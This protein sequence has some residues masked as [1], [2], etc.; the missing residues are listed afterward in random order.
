[1]VNQKKAE[2]SFRKMNYLPSLFG[3]ALRATCRL[4][5]VS[6]HINALGS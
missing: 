5:S 6:S 1:M 4:Q 2:L 3:T